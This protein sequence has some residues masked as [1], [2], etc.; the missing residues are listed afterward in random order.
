MP[1]LLS[2]NTAALSFVGADVGGFFGDTDAELMSRWMQ[3]GAYQPFFRGHAH[4]DAKRREPWM[5]GDEWTALMRKA[6]MARYALLPYWYTVFHEASI[7]GMPV[8]R[9]MWMQYPMCEA[10][11]DLDDQ[12]LI[13]SDL[14]VK[15]VTKQGATQ[16]M[17]SFPAVDRWYD[18]DTLKVYSPRT[19]GQTDQRLDVHVTLEKIPVFQRGG[20]IIPRRLRLRRSSETMT[21]DPYTL[22]IALDDEEKAKGNLY[23]DDGHSFDHIRL[24]HYGLA[25]F[26][27]DFKSYIKNTVSSPSSWAIDNKDDHMIERFIVMGVHEVPKAIKHDD[28]FLDFIYDEVSSVIT[29]RKPNISAMENWSINIEF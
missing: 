25:K 19:L 14:L 8:M 23:V 29:V 2:L 24:G 27:I 16:V 26:S 1:M 17:V 7:T 11:Y 9:S 10:L 6:A 21:K 4:H 5:F 22:Y 18:V 15:P 12:Y 13:G 20:S 3:A 28:R